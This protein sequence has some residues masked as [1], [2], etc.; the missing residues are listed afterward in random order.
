MIQRNTPT[1]SRSTQLPYNV[2]R[3]ILPTLVHHYENDESLSFWGSDSVQKHCLHTRR[4]GEGSCDEGRVYEKVVGKKAANVRR[5][6]LQRVRDDGV[7]T[8]GPGVVQSRVPI[9]RARARPR[10]SLDTPASPLLRLFA[11]LQRILTPCKARRPFKN[12]CWPGCRF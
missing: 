5:D 7:P 11:C 9:H 4:T 1:F 3:E 2:I 12:G 10:R 8:G 6:P